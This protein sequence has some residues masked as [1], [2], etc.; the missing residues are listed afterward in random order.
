MKWKKPSEKISLL[1]KERLKNVE[2]QSRIMFGCPSYFINGN[3]FIGAYGDD[4]FIRLA[5]TDIDE[6]LKK[7]PHAKRFE[8]RPGRVMKEYVAL[9]KSV[10]TKKDIFSELLRKSI[11]YTRSLPRKKKRSKR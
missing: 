1:L 2:C 10:Y 6:K 9:P 4:I 5:P 7:F 11:S 8:P 3:M